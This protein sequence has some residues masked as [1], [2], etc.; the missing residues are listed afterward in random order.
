MGIQKLCV[1]VRGCVRVVKRGAYSFC[2]SVGSPP[3]SWSTA[4][5]PASAWDSSGDS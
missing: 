5:A 4:S 3:G 2:S 1:R